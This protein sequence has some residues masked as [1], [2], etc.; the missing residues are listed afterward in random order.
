MAAMTW[1]PCELHD[2]NEFAHK[3]M[4]TRQAHE[5]HV[6]S[7]FGKILHLVSFQ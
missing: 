5:A 1:R 4:S 2:V 7:M 6:S 3:L